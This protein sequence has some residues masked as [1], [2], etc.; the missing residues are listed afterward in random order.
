VEGSMPIEVRVDETRELV[1]MVFAGEV[2]DSEFVETI[3][4]YLLEPYAAFPRGLFDLSDVTVVGV[5]ADSVR[6]AARHATR[7]V[8]SR[9][10]EGKLAI[11]APRDVLFGLAR[12][13]SILRDDS[14]VEV[15]AFRNR[16]E[17]ES[18][19]GLTKNGAYSGE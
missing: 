18:W 7:H 4:H 14:P 8:D 11:V 10:E 5:S 1:E 17:A 2:T 16:N 15:R 19:L 12:M 9:L 13:Y 3:D 6:H